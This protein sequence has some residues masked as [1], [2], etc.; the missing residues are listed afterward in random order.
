MFDHDGYQ[1]SWYSS[2][3]NNFLLFTSGNQAQEFNTL[4]YIGKQCI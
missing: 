3:I 4:T 1:D 2:I